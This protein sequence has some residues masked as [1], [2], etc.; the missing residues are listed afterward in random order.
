VSLS[1]AARYY[2]LH[3]ALLT[4]ALGIGAL[5]YNLTINA[6]GYERIFLGRL[7]TIS[8]LASLLLL[9]PLWLPRCW[10]HGWVK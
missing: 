9:L 6:L 3:A 7:E 1:P 5:F 4:G 8:P 2:L 10:L